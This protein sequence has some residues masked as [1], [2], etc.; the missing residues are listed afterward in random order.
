[1]DKPVILVVEDNQTQQKVI[2]LLAEEFGFKVMVVSTGAEALEAM[3]LSSELFRLILMDIALPDFDGMV[4]TQR[5]RE[6]YTEK[7]IPVIAMSAF[8]A[9]N[10][11]KK[12]LD[13]GMDDYLEKPFSAR[14]F[15]AVLNKWSEQ[16]TVTNQ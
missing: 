13:A 10:L 8:S 1:M 2:A 9:D 5:L 3:G 14:E 4:C 16:T 15:E 11:R 6:M 7:H 12:C